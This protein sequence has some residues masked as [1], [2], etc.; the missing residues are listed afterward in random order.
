MKSKRIVWMLLFS[1]AVLAASL[2]CSVSTNLPFVSQAE[3][4]ATRRA[5]RVARATFTPLPQ[6]TEIPTLEPTEE[7]T[8]APTLEPTEEPP[9]PVPATKKPAPK[10]TKPPAPPPAQ[11]TNPPEPAATEA[12]KFPYKAS[13]VTCTHA[14]NAYIKGSVC[15]D[16]KCQAKLSGMIVVM[17]DAPHGTILDKVKT[18][19]SGDFT[20]T[21]NGGG[22]VGNPENWYF[23]V[24][25]AQ[26][27]PL[28]DAGGPVP[29]DQGHNS[30]DL[31]N[32]CPNTA[33]FISFYKP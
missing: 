15:S 7:P 2:A 22:P 11:P 25:N 33:A 24:V 16:N 3:P 21:R 26:D 8:E 18:D 14:G 31:I 28:S 5:T 4:T 17:S 32:K 6:A 29:L 20:F 12:P 10:A 23:W 19:V 9:T 30:D 1:V 13:I 27:Q